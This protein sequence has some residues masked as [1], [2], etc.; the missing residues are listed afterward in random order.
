MSWRTW[1]VATLAMAPLAACSTNN[2]DADRV[3][4]PPPRP[5]PPI[6]EDTSSGIEDATYE[7]MMSQDDY[8]AQAQR[9]I[10]AANADAEFERLQKELQGED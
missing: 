3:V 1:I 10:D 5:S 7:E 8:D 4:N 9:D 6:V 2:N